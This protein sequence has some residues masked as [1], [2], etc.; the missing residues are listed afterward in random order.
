MAENSSSAN[1]DPE[2]SDSGLEETEST[3]S[4]KEESEPTDSGAG[5]SLFSPEAVVML[6]L[7]VVVDV[8]DFLIGSLVVVDI[9]AI[10]FFGTWM[11][12]RSHQMAVTTR[13]VRALKAARTMR[14]LRPLLIIIDCIPI[15][16]MLPCWI[17]V[18]Y[19]ELKQ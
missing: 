5:G 11:Y 16:G 8:F 9:I 3:D 2:P 14:W 1:K 15:V 13:S 18:V 4:K 7:A 10:L 19:F 12:F 17:L 6:P